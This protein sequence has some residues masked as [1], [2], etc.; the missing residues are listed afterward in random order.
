MTTNTRDSYIENFTRLQPSLTGSD[1]DWLVRL[2]K[3]AITRLK[4]IGFPTETDE[5]WR[6][7]DTSR[8]LQKA[9]DQSNKQHVEKS[10]VKSISERWSP[11]GLNPDLLSFCNGI[12]VSS[13]S[14]IGTGNCINLKSFIESD[15]DK[16]SQYL[17][18][19][20]GPDENGF[21]LLNLAFFNDGALVN[22]PQGNV[23]QHPIHLQFSSIPDDKTFIC[24]LR[25]LIIL[26][27]NSRGTVIMTFAGEGAYFT[28]SV[29][30]IY[31]GENSSLELYKIDD[32]SDSAF[33]I[34][35]IHA[36][37]ERNSNLVSHAISLNGAIVRNDFI[38]TL[39]E[40]GA[41]C[42]LNGLYMLSGTQHV[43]NHTT[44]D[45]A[46]P[47]CS[48]R[49][50]YKGVLD[51]KSRAVFNGRIIVRPD[52]QKT[53]AIQTNKNM[54]LSDGALAN[55][56]PVLEIFANDVKCKHG[57]TIGQISPD[58]MFYLRSRGIDQ[59]QAR[60]LLI[61]AFTSEM[62]GRMNTSSIR[63]KLEEFILKRFG[64]V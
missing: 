64:N 21:S 57:A 29:T 62:L 16:P 19:L 12:A 20:A 22:I 35:T 50:L 36:R 18:K 10:L 61:Y 33:H 11:A 60:R 5:D 28:N 27:P 34:S 9:F 55:T 49:E 48:S 23:T 2:R 44:I 3:S 26:G 52:A 6:F 41:E 47:H 56:K 43:D 42:T 53:D 58:E 54:I 25:T 63:N 46:K 8:L 37:Q 24:H 39:A 59:Q 31:L 13:G 17:G 7:T 14:P 4:E 15:H 1:I 38:T 51:G 45:H 40:D 32:E 30:E